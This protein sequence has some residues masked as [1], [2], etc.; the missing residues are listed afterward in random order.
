MFFPGAGTAFCFALYAAG[1]GAEGVSAGVLCV[2]ILYQGI[3]GVCARTVAGVFGDRTDGAR[4]LDVHDNDTH[5]GIS[6]Y[7]REAYK[8][9]L[10]FKKF[11][12]YL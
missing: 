2:G 1:I 4:Q 11:V 12:V 3:F 9:N 7:H 10:T 5:G 6:H 8:I